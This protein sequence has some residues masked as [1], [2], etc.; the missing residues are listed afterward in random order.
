RLQ[1]QVA[2]AFTTI[3]A[4]RYHVAG[5]HDLYHLT[6]EENAN[7][8]GQSVAS[9]VIDLGAWQLLLWRAD[10]KITW[11]ETSRGFSLPET[12]YLWLSRQIVAAEKPSLIATHVPVSG[13]S[14][15]GNYYFQANPD[16]AG[17]PQSPRVRAALAQAKVPVVCLAGHVHWNTVT[18]IDGIFHLTQQSLTESFT[19]GGTPAGAM[20]ILELGDEISWHVSGLDP[21]ACSFRPSATRW[22]PPLQPFLRTRPA[23]SKE[24]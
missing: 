19:T 12:D 10:A 4:P 2:D 9:E 21:F 14:Q 1:E 24:G 18:Q 7:L 13:H 11:T 15:I 20:A 16:V 22:T 23:V 5:N 17:Y 6:A 3:S 8:L